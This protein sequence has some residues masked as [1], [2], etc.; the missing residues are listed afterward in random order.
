[1]QPFLAKVLS[2]KSPTGPP[3]L[4]SGRPENEFRMRVLTC[5]GV[6][7]FKK[8]IHKQLIKQ[9]LTVAPFEALKCKTT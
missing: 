7:F 3:T 4:Q 5:Q 6:A 2:K 8:Q 9:I 1:M